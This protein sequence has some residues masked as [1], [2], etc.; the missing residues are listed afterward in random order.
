MS[1]QERIATPEGKGRYVRQLFATIADRYDLITIV[2]SYGRDRGWKRRLTDLAS[3]RSDSRVLDL[4]T[5]TGDIAFQVQRRAGTVVGLDITTRMIELAKGKAEHQ[6]RGKLPLFLVADMLALPFRSESFDLV[7]TG[8]GLRN[9]PDL[10]RAVDEI[11]RVL[12]PGGQ[13]LSLDFDRPSNRLLRG[14]YLRYLTL[15]GGAL[16]WVLHRDPDTYRYIPASIRN[17]PGAPAVAS[18]MESRGFLAVR[19]YPVLGGLMAIHHARKG[20]GPCS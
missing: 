12:K 9:V 5:G 6:N 20:G 18:L 3:P 7:T 17:Y 19:H 13:A 16:G 11:F 4:A 10:T 1:V 2:L 8:Y 14:A 15:V